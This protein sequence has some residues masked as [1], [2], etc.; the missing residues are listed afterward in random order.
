MKIPA[1]IA[2]IISFLFNITFESQTVITPQLVTCNPLVLRFTYT[3]TISPVVTVSWDFGQG[4]TSTLSTPGPVNFGA[5]NDTAYTVTLVLNGTD[6]SHILV[7]RPDPFFTYSHEFDFGS[8]SIIFQA[9]VTYNCFPPYTYHW[10][11]PMDMPD[12][13]FLLHPYDMPGSAY[14]VQLIVQDALG[15]IYTLNSTVPVTDTIGIPNVFTP[16]DD[17]RNDELK[18]Y[19]NGKDLISLKIF[20]RTGQ[21]V[22]ETQAR[23]LSWDGRL[24]SGQ[25]ASPGIYYYIITRGGD[26]PVNK[27]GFFYIYL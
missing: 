17:G 10:I 2:I 9:G 23:I 11:Q 5:N 12:Q 21:M 27:V 20:T 25:K 22:Y 3:T 13:S 26:N 14:P 19:S 7:G 24:P 18:I 1:Y 15:C 6:I 4:T 16:N 8:Y